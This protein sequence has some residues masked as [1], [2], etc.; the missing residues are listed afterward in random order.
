MADDTD[1][2]VPPAP[3]PQDKGRWRVAPAPDGRGMPDDHKPPPPHRLRGFWILLLV[4][5]A[6]NWVGL[7][8]A[9]PSEPPRVKVPFSPYFLQQVQAGKV[10]SISSKGGTINGT[11]ASKVVYPPG[12]RT[13]KPT[14]LFSTEVPTF[15][16]NA[17]LTSLPICS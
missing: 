8:M 4:L 17:S 3:M 16:D 14:T 1:K 7:L 13:A 11:F 12:S 9:K 6:I 5:L 2:A 10:T 15:W